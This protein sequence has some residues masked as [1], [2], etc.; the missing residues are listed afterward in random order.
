[1]E[2]YISATEYKKFFNHINQT[3][4]IKELWQ[5]WITDNWNIHYI[6]EEDEEE[7]LLTLKNVF[8]G[9]EDEYCRWED[10]EYWIT[11]EG[12]EDYI[13]SEK[14]EK[15]RIC[16]IESEFGAWIGVN[17]YYTD[18]RAEELVEIFYDYK[19]TEEDVKNLEKGQNVHF[20]QIKKQV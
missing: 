3:K 1:M 12:I 15:K 11:F 16:F 5:K 10:F 17:W 14:L 9:D 19:L 4:L 20:E 18:D 13:D 6:P 2:K 8:N 7:R